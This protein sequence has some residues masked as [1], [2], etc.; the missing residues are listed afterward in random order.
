LGLLAVFVI[1]RYPRVMLIEFSTP[2]CEKV[3][4]L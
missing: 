2:D 1:S 4:T 3:D